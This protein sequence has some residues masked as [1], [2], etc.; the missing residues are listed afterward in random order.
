MLMVAQ[1][2]FR[3]LKAPELPSKVYAGVQYEEGV[4]VSREEVAA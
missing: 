4:E 1:K 3:R 2:R